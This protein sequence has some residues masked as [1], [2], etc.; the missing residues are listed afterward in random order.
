M[1]LKNISSWHPL[2]SSLVASRRVYWVAVRQP[3][4]QHLTPVTPLGSTQPRL[5]A[6]GTL[7]PILVEDTST[8]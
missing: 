6:L 8:L 4:V 2:N 3:W 5:A 1:Y 7:V